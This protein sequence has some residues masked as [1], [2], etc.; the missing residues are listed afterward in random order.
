MQNSNKTTTQQNQKKQIKLKTL[1]PNNN[2]DNSDMMSNTESTQKKKILQKFDNNKI[3]TL[4][5]LCEQ[6]YSSVLTKQKNY[7]TTLKNKLNGEVKHSTKWFY[8]Y[9][10]NKNAIW[11]ILLEWSENQPNYYNEDENNEGE[12]DVSDYMSI[13]DIKLK[14]KTEKDVNDFLSIA[15]VCNYCPE[16]VKAVV[17]QQKN[18]NKLEK[19]HLQLLEK[20]SDIGSKNEIVGQRL[21]IIWVGE[22]SDAMDRF[23][24]DRIINGEEPLFRTRE[25]LIAYGYEL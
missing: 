5:I 10:C 14:Y 9:E 1:Y 24:F 13:F 11:E 3:K 6:L 25:E 18:I 19:K 17:Y 7:I 21:N 22:V 2:S 4:S 23:D 16:K 8:N 12:E 20:L 15:T